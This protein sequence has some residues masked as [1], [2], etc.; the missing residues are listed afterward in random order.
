VK[1]LIPVRFG[2]E[3]TLSPFAIN[4]WR[5]APNSISAIFDVKNRDMNGARKGSIESAFFC[6]TRLKIHCR[7]LRNIQHFEAKGWKA[8][9]LDVV[10]GLGDK[11]M[12]DRGGGCLATP[13]CPKPKDPN[14]RTAPGLILSKL[15]DPKPGYSKQRAIPGLVLSKAPRLARICKSVHLLS[16]AI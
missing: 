4:V 15:N 9:A 7:N 14:Q 2:V 16:A 5:R 8:D 6:K 11:R 12:V 10:P 13:G 1:P 3:R